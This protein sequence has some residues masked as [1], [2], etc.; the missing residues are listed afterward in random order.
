VPPWPG[1]GTHKAATA[2]RRRATPRVGLRVTATDSDT[3]TGSQSYTLMVDP[4]PLTLTADGRVMTWG[5][6]VPA[7]T[8]RHTDLVNGGASASPARG[9]ATTATS[10]SNGGTYA[11]TQG[12]LAAAGNYTVGT[13]HQGTLTVGPA[14]LTVTAV[15]QAMTYG[16][17][18]ALTCKHAGL[19]NGG[20]SATFPG[21]LAVTGNY[22]IATFNGGTPAV[23]PATL[24][25]EKLKRLPADADP[26]RHAEGLRKPHYADGLGRGP[27]PPA[28]TSVRCWAGYFEALGPPWAV[29]WR[30]SDSLSLRA[31]LGVPCRGRPR[32][33]PASPRSASGRRWACPSGPSWSCP[34]SP[35]RSCCGARR[36]PWAR[37]RWGPTR[38]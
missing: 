19:V 20:A 37:R 31:F 6:G 12:A 3:D 30:C 9:L 22:A 17:V 33:T 1:P 11:V 4:A 14:G 2:A 32:T 24:V 7:L 15:N 13:F 23:N 8:C 26:D 29:A 35:G 5:G 27:A 25:Q 28:P 10:G 21:G 18:P 16:G 34:A 36:W 38:R